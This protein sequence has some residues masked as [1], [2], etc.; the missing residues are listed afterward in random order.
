MDERLHFLEVALTIRGL[1]QRRRAQGHS[2]ILLGDSPAPRAQETHLW[3]ELGTL[4][5][6][7][8][9]RKRTSHLLVSVVGF[10]WDEGRGRRLRT[11]ERSLLR[12]SNM[13][14]LSESGRLRG[15]GIRRLTAMGQS[16]TL[17]HGQRGSPGCCA[18]LA[19]RLPLEPPKILEIIDDEM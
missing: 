17:R 5:V 6:G 18:G 19:S 14:N 10:R 15:G 3:C 12:S 8:D 13:H 4:E 7:G 2:G 9:K 16:D 1:Y 11:T